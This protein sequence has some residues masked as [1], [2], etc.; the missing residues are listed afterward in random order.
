MNDP[1]IVVTY[2]IADERDKI[3]ENINI[4]A[5]LGV[6]LFYVFLDNCPE[7]LRKDLH[8]K[9]GVRILDSCSFRPDKDTP[10][11]VLQYISRGSEGY[12]IRK[13]VNTFHACELAAEEFGDAWVLSIDADEIILPGDESA[14]RSKNNL[15]KEFFSQVKKNV[16][17]VRF[18]NIEVVPYGKDVPFVSPSLFLKR[19][20]EMC[21]NTIRV[22]RRLVRAFRL[23]PVWEEWMVSFCYW[24]FGYGV[25]FSYSERSLPVPYYNGY[26]GYKSAIRTPYHRRFIFSVHYWLAR[27]KGEKLRSKT[28]DVGYCLHFDIYCFDGFMRKFRQA[29]KMEPE[30]RFHYRKK[31]IDIVKNGSADDIRDLYFDCVAISRERLRR[32][33]RLLV[34]V[35][36]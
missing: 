4:H 36:L 13:C 9:R 3:F 31:I 17:Q 33:S 23:G 21:L 30:S 20:G 24:I 2:T 18:K 29:S 8:A 12:D 22:G 25:R 5:R 7:S 35:K 34:K 28:I 1:K 14:L 27:L 11:W 16:H 19:P 15:L 26:V 6:D 32:Y 10:D